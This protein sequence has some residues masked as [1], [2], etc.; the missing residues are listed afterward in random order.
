LRSSAASWLDGNLCP[1]RLPDARLTGQ[2]SAYQKWLDRVTKWSGWAIERGMSVEF[3][4]WGSHEML[5]RLAL[6]A[7][8][9]LPRF[10]FDAAALDPLWFNKRLQ[11]A[12][13]TAGPRYTPEVNVDLAIMQDFDAFGRTAAWIQRL[14]RFAG[15]TSKVA[16][17]AGYDLDKLGSQRG[18]VE[19]VLTMVGTVVTMIR[20]ITVD[21]TSPVSFATIVDQVKNSRTAINSA[22]A[23]LSNQERLEDQKPNDSADRHYRENPFRSSR[24]RLHDVERVL[25]EA[26]ETLAYTESLA[27]SSIL[28][29]DGTAGMGKTHLL[30]DLASKRQATGLP[31]ILLMGQR[32]LQPGEPWTQALQ[33]LDLAQWTTEDFI[34]ALEAMA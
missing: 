12:I 34:G 5:E 15:Q 13:V 11:E 21:P 4:W 30:C 8:A 32:F 25:G 29:L 26:L 6:P 20:E 10:W 31:T 2:T 7:N 24:F 17:L 33:Q 14:K 19:N 27:Q 16:R 3:I 9:G 18:Q 1:K 23:E 28:V 22:T